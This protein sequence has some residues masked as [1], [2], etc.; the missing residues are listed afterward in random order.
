MPSTNS[1]TNFR[2]LLSIE[3]AIDAARVH[4]SL[5]AL[6]ETYRAQARVLVQLSRHTNGVERH[7]A[8]QPARQLVRVIR[9]LEKNVSI[10]ALRNR[11]TTRDR[12]L[13]IKHLIEMLLF[14]YM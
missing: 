1:L 6:R 13:E 8:V 12:V 9:Q 11:V 10:P 4:R 7:L 14:P 2:Q 3:L 5:H